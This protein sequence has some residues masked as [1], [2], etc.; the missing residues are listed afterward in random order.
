M[1]SCVKADC[2]YFMVHASGENDNLKAFS[3]PYIRQFANLEVN[4]E[5]QS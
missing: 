1:Q 3:G 4:V 5:S 2:L